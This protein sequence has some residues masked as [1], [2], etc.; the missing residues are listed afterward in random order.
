M[1]GGV[2]LVLGRAGRNFGAGMS[3]G[4]AFVLDD[5][6][7][8]AGRCN[9][10]MIAVEPLVDKGDLALV[11]GLLEEHVERTSSVRASDLLAAWPRSAPRFRKVI[12]TEYRR[13][14]DAAKAA[15]E[16]Q[17]A[18]VRRQAVT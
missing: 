13:I 10:G 4:V 3:G 16:T 5:D 17:E 7:G 9:M 14:L 6:G 8:F 15:A 11:A 18:P 12:P 1:T 2:V